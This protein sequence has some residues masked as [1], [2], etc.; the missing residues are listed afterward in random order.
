MMAIARFN[1]GLEFEV[2]AKTSFD[3][4]LMREGDIIAGETVYEVGESIITI[5]YDGKE[6]VRKSYR[7]LEERADLAHYIKETRISKD[8]VE[9]EPYLKLL[10][11]GQN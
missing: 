7:I 11:R 5:T 3:P 4:K 10:W 8:N 2:D 6:V 9:I 1:L